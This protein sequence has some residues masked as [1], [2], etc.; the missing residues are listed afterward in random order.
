MVYLCVLTS[1]HICG[2][3]VMR[4]DTKTTLLGCVR[5]GN[6]DFRYAIK[7]EIQKGEILKKIG[8]MSSRTVVSHVL[9]SRPLFT[10]RREQF[11]TILLRISLK[12]KWKKG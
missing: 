5:L 7:H 3:K 9:T 10:R 8:K 1:T 6:V 11:F 4:E 12:I 2:G